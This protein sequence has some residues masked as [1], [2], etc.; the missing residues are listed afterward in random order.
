MRICF[1]MASIY[2]NDV[3]EICEFQN[4][5]IIK[6]LHHA[7]V[8]VDTSGVIYLIMCCVSLLLRIVGSETFSDTRVHVNMFS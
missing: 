3:F 7:C 8:D 2:V 5:I 4:I 1:Y 6:I